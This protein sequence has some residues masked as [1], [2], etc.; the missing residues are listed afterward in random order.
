MSEWQ[1]IGFLE[2]WKPA[3]QKLAILDHADE[4]IFLDSNEA[5]NFGTPSAVVKEE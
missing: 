1:A 5:P 4:L 3:I 2:S